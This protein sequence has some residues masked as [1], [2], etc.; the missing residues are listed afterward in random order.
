MPCNRD[1]RQA[2]RSFVQN[3]SGYR[4]ARTACAG[5]SLASAFFRMPVCFLYGPL[6]FCSPF[7]I[8]RTQLFQAKNAD[9]TVSFARAIDSSSSSPRENGGSRGAHVS[10]F[11]QM[12]LVHFHRAFDPD[13]PVKP[14]V[15]H[16]PDPT[17]TALSR[18]RSEASDWAWNPPA[19][20]GARD[21]RTFCPEC[22]R[23]DHPAGSSR[24]RA[25]R[26]IQRRC[27]AHTRFCL[28]WAYTGS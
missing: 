7:Q 2:A 22:R 17:W 9:Q 4:A 3:G 12:V 16:R 19:A 27:S 18:F 15:L 23:P 8:S 6:A 11:S 21:G 25:F 1:R 24:G 28:A 14:D 13:H 26:A 20:D 5:S 10:G